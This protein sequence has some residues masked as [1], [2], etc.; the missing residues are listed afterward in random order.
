MVKRRLRD[1]DLYDAPSPAKEV[2]VSPLE[3]GRFCPTC[4]KEARIVSNRLGVTAYC[5][6]CGT[7]WGI[8]GSR[9]VP[10]EVMARPRG[11]SK[12]TF[13][14]PDTSIAYES[15]EEDQLYEPKLWEE[16]DE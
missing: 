11:L 16:T 9:F 5:G 7:H 15:D 1:T 14:A 3:A 13:M 2:T 6:P 8:S 10:P 12:Q 4:G